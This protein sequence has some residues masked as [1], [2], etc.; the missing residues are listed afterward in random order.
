MVLKVLSFV[1]AEFW[2][3]ASTLAHRRPRGNYTPPSRPSY[4]AK[5]GESG[6]GCG[7]PFA[8]RAGAIRQVLR[9]TFRS[10]LD[11]LEGAGLQHWEK[12]SFLL[13]P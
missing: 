9:M 10:C 8:D 2:M 5:V 12:I 4:F 13:Q 1:P 7:C 11:T 6:A 3:P